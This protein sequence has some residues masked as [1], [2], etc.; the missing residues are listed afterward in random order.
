MAISATAPTYSLK[1]AAGSC[2]IASGANPASGMRSAGGNDGDSE[3]VQYGLL[4]AFK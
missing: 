3:W 4:A 1:T 2:C